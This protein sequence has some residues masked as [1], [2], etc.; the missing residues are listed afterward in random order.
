MHKVR[1]R[2]GVNVFA[3][4][5]ACGLPRAC[6]AGIEWLPPVRRG[7]VDRLLQARADR[8]AQVLVVCDG[9]FQSEPAVSHA[10]LCRA[11]DRGWQVW[12]VSSIGAI[13]AHEL[14]REG[15]HGFG[16]VY[17]QF[18]RHADFSDDEMCLLHLPMPPYTPWTEALVNVRHAL[19]SHGPA[20]GI[21]PAARRRVISALR[22]C[23]FGERSTELVHDLM[24]G[25]GGIAPASA[26]ALID[27]IARHPVKL[28]D[29]RQLLTE[30]PWNRTRPATAI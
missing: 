28:A 6:M 29:L 18:S 7:D 30:R 22:E 3:G 1:H 13:R 19:H 21:G 23:W 10:E 27:T 14:R 9:L 17:A 16:W 15:M 5:S 11:L 24:V 2:T 8:P 26:H 25:P 4:P 12:G 20:L